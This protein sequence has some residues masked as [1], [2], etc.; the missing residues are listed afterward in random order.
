VAAR[1][2]AAGVLTYGQ[3]PSARALFT[4]A[5]AHRG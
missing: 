2:Y 1:I 5:F 4:A 3:K